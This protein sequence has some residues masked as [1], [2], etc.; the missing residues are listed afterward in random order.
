MQHPRILFGE[1][2]DSVKQSDFGPFRVKV[3]DGT[4]KG[5]GFGPAVPLVNFLAGPTLKRNSLLPDLS[6]PPCGP[7]SL[8]SCA[9]RLTLYVS[10]R[11]DA[12]KAFENPDVHWRQNLRSLQKA[13]Y[14]KSSAVASGLHPRRDNAQ[15]F[16][17]DA[18]GRWAADGQRARKC[19]TSS[20]VALM[21]S[22]L[23]GHRHNS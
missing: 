3:R 7:R 21:E 22:E 13:S 2:R 16:D 23:K 1:Q 10:S 4:A 5:F 18:D 14:V 8:S 9:R 19:L 17:V 12:L 6:S 20:Y 11:G 15:G